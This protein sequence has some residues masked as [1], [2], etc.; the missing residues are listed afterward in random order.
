M[1]QYQIQGRIGEGAHG[2]VFKAR[3]I[4][5]IIPAGFLKK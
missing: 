4:E 2:I 3:H 5:V 1:E